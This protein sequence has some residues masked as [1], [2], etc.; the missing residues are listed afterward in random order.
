MQ[1][2]SRMELP[3]IRTFSYHYRNKF[4]TP[5]GKIPVD[6]G[7]PCPNRLKG[8]CIFCRAAA[9]SPGYLEDKGNVKS[10]IK[11]GRKQLLGGRFNKYFIYFQQETPTAIQ[12]E[13]LLPIVEE[14]IADV[15]CVG[16]IIST[17]PDYLKES[18]LYKFSD[19]IKKYNKDCLFELGLQSIKPSSLKY[20][21]R[22]HSY[23]DF[24]YA[25][26]LL[27]SFGTFEVGV[28]LLLG[29]PGE[30][31]ED[32]ISSIQKVCSLGVDALKIHH[33]QVL[34]DTPLERIYEDGDVQLFSKNDYL[35]LLIKIL[36][37]VPENV[38]IHRLWATAHPQML[39]DTRWNILAAELSDGLRQMMDDRGIRQGDLCITS[40]E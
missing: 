38:V 10:Q 15:D 23:A 32:M 11:R 1:Y 14:V 29:I 12:D 8:G 21:N 2:P 37:M 19:L 17:R 28:H 26:Q 36:P 30:T 5:V 13:I 18:F 33:L 40:P 22:N 7:E 20:L 16:L 9:F 25:V 31:E 27:Q 35:E 3:H 24:L 4:G 6:L 39:I 34:K